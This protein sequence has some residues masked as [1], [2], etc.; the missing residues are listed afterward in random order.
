MGNR[1]RK[2]ILI[3][4]VAILS[5]S[6]WFG[7]SAKAN[8]EDSAARNQESMADSAND[9]KDGD[10]TA[11]GFPEQVIGPDWQTAQGDAAQRGFTYLA[12]ENARVAFYVNEA[13]NI[14]VY[15]KTADA[16]YTSI[17]SGED[18]IAKAV[19]KMNLGSD[20]QVLFVDQN[21]STSIKNSLTG[22]VKDG[23]VSL[24]ACEEGMKVWYYFSEMDVCFS[25]WYRLTE[26]G[27][28]V[29]V[30][31]EDI[32]EELETG[33]KNKVV[34]AQY[35]LVQGV[36][37]ENMGVNEAIY[38]GIQE[39]SVLPYFGA[40]GP[41]DEGYL[42]IPDGSGALINFNNQKSFY[43]AYS[44]D[45]YGRDPVL[46]LEIS[47]KTAENVLL[48]VFGAS[49][50]SHGFVAA[51]EKGAASANI[52]AMTS[53]LLTSYNN[54]YI[55][56]RYRQSMSLS[57]AVENTYNANNSRVLANTFVVDNNYSEG[58]YELRYFLLDEE[59][60]D[61]VGMA[62]RYRDHLV[63]QGLTK[64]VAA[65][66]SPLYLTLYGGVAQTEYFLGIPY[67]A[68]TELT[69]YRQAQGILQEMTDSGVEQMIV[70]FRGWQKDGVESAVP[71]KV[72]TESALGKKA[73]W[74]Q[75]LQYAKEQ[76]IWLYA[77][78]DFVNL[79]RSGNGYRL[80]RDAVQNAGGEAA[81]QYTYDL[82]TGARCDRKDSWRLLNPL[83]SET[84]LQRF[85]ER[86]EGLGI[87]Y[88]SLGSV[89]SILTSD[90]SRKAFGLHRDDAAKLFS[91]MVRE[92]GESC[93][94]VMVETGNLYAAM[95]ADHITDV[96]GD[97]TH[98]DLADETVPFYQIVMHGYVSYSTEPINLTPDP[99]RA[100]LK[101]LETG[102]SLGYALIYGDTR[103]LA[104]TKYNF[105]FNA[106][107][108]DWYASVLDAYLETKE[109][110][111]AVA[112]SCITGH[113]KL[114]ENVYRTDYG[115]A[116]SVY[117]NYGKKDV[118]IDDLTVPARDYVFL[119]NRGD[120]GE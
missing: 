61:Y 87:E 92:A 17:P 71:A 49:Y 26:D 18:P 116:G 101:A 86:R 111:E 74:T 57:R 9:T 70:R 25:V 84:A 19:N 100:V 54:V 36:S 44:Q 73:D 3:V 43:G 114:A 33:R 107:Y 96:A 83:K 112:D 32:M 117:V 10:Q 11:I 42:F 104:D 115:Q 103:K 53:G 67:E 62:E 85:L 24:T 109:C 60:A 2:W 47:L 68:V 37:L 28:T 88:L 81:L 39:I 14:G 5:G 97:S 66:E 8:E 76:G 108:E 82:N 7:V 106:K 94:G 89:G 34:D 77:D 30:P 55:K 13:G 50:G 120:G 12:M 63:D 41:E 69:D 102:S 78:L 35:E 56:F 45:F 105:L 98:F 31:F 21:G 6:I 65:G 23:N 16:W 95:Y 51:V 80:S 93:G 118:T 59:K 79:Y 22:A 119:E 20:F 29:T 27:F 52:N 90:F 15:D 75:L 40:A 58:C 64:K 46:N 48:P 113:E 99:D 38:Y 1:M 110:F 72:K 91:E 4:T